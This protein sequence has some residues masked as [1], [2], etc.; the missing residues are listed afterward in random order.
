MKTLRASI[1]SAACRIG[2]LLLGEDWSGY[3]PRRHVYVQIAV[4]RVPDIE[5]TLET[6]AI[7]RAA[8]VEE[9]HGARRAWAEY[10]QAQRWLWWES[11]KRLILERDQP[12]GEV[13]ELAPT[14]WAKRADA[15]TKLR[16]MQ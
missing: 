4:D 11:Q 16:T 6:R 1:R 5:D 13:R 10:Q 8:Q 7:F 12:K 3:R 15:V 9:I 14:A 2:F